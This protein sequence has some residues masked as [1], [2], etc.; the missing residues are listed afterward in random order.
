MNYV[1]EI[2]IYGLMNKNAS[3]KDEYSFYK[4]KDKKKLTQ[5]RHELLKEEESQYKQ[6]NY[7]YLDEAPH[8]DRIYNKIYQIS[9]IIDSTKMF[10]DM[11]GKEYRELRQ[12]RNKYDGN[13]VIKKLSEETKNDVLSV[14]DIWK[15][16]QGTKYG[17]QQHIGIDKAIINRY[18][19]GILANVI[20]FVFY[21]DGQCI[22]YSTI[23]TKG[24]ICDGK[25]T[26][27]YLT[28]KV[29]FVGRNITEYID[30]ATFRELYKITHDSEFIINWGCS[31]GGVA[32]YKENKWPL[33]KKEP[34]Y[35]CTFKNINYVENGD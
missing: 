32:W 28:R 6:V 14:I 13:V 19:D 20:A 4:T 29:L 21:L 17:W 10:G 16:N 22:G 33:Y 26:Y 11:P 35:F 3:F 27:N 31:S 9:S 34:K 8:K 1:D 7:M 15:V 24:H 12:T 18:C 30:F 23:A 25:K 2:S 5:C